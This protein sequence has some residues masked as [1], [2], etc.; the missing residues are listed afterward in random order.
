MVVP[1]E[2]KDTSLQS[3]VEYL[4][5]QIEQRSGGRAKANFVLNVP[6][7]VANKKV[8]LQMNHVPVTA[9]LEYL[10]NLAGVSFSVEKYAIVVTPAAI[11]NPPP[12]TAT[13][14]PATD[15]P[16]ATP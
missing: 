13:G 4:R 11:S 7:E 1:V 9:L 8:T 3:A 6:P 14:V 5:Q 16:A 15:P 10:G 2:F 12:P